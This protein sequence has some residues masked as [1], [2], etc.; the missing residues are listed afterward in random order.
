MLASAGR[1]SLHGYDGCM[2]YQVQGASRRNCRQTHG[3]TP[4]SSQKVFLFSRNS[5]VRFWCPVLWYLW[6]GRAKNPGPGF[7]IVLLLTS[8][9]SVV[10]SLMVILL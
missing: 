1:P 4:F 7:P 2:V 3:K 5:R 9:M 6:I 10:G 8:L